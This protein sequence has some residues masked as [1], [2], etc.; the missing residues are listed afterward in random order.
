MQHG[1]FD[2]EFRLEKIDS[3]GD[4]LRKLAD[5]IDWEM[6][7]AELE[8]ARDRDK[9]RKSPAGRKP[10]DAVLMFKILI[11][12][13]LYGLSDDAA[14]FQ[15]LDR[16]SF[17]R[18][19]G[20]TPGGAVPDAK[21][22]WLFRSQLTEA[23]AID[24][25]FDR[26]DRFLT[27]HGYAARRG[28]IVD[29][30]IVPVP[31]QRN[32]RAENEAIRR[33]ETP[34]GWEENPAKMRQ[35]DTDAAWTK[36]HDKS[37]YG[38]KNHANVDVEHKL[39]RVWEVTDASVHDSLMLRVLLDEDNT[40]AEVYGDAAYRSRAIEDLLREGNYNSRI[41]SKAARGRPLSELEK[42]GNK[43]KSRTRARIEHV[44]GI[45]SRRAGGG[46][47]R[48][49]GWARM[50]TKIGLRNLAYNLDRYAMLER[51]AG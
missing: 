16:L 1:L 25:L 17:M 11:L 31:V 23:G 21:T 29:A 33:G 12:Q 36:K 30:S 44:F 7:R 26:F 8:S 51:R 13:S 46:L 35:K 40:S 5:M 9:E 3:N 37:Y 2:L 38:Y 14:E 19:L 27:N 28:Q 39:I 34:E 4:P 18:F 50:R 43:T 32:T 45:M 49:V 24:A 10:W 48:A 20:L 15:I 6:F 47:M 42:K 41:H 22:I